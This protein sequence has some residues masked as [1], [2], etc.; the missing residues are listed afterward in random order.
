M[1]HNKLY[2]IDN[3]E[4]YLNLIYIRN[5]ICNNVDD[6][7]NKY[8]FKIIQKI[9]KGVDYILQHNDKMR[10]KINLEELSLSDLQYLSYASHTIPIFTNKYFGK[11]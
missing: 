7:D 9:M 11:M 6:I 5:F 3:N 2:V 1:K 8:D 10:L 4:M